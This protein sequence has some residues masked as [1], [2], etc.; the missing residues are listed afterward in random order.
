MQYSLPQSSGFIGH[1][2]YKHISRDKQQKIITSH[3]KY[4]NN[5][6]RIYNFN[7]L[8]RAV[9]AS[10]DTGTKMTN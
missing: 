7:D 1:F 5:S 8:T 4:T 6:K 9:P 2:R 3:K 10:V